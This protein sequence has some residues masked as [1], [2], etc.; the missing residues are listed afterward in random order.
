MASQLHALAEVED[1]GGEITPVYQDGLQKMRPW[2]TTT[3][4]HVLSTSPVEAEGFPGLPFS[5]SFVVSADPQSLL[6]IRTFWSQA[7]GGGGGV[8]GG[9]GV[10]HFMGL[11][12]PSTTQS[13]SHGA[14]VAL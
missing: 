1:S 9:V 4:L 3:G 8:G 5:S 13:P 2:G 7:G 12:P 10:A 14:A 11:G 6:V